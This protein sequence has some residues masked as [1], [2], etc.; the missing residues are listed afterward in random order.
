MYMTLGFCGTIVIP[1]SEDRLVPVVAR[2]PSYC[3][4]FCD[5]VFPMTT[6]GRSLDASEDTMGSAAEAEESAL[7]FWAMALVV[8]SSG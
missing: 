2:S 5:C 8:P 7:S 3:F 4:C 1:G 6:S